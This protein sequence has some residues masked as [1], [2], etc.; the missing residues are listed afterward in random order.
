MTDGMK[1]RLHSAFSLPSCIAN[2]NR[3]RAAFIGVLVIGVGAYILVKKPL[4]VNLSASLPLGLYA[5]ADGE[6][7]TGKLVEFRRP[8][9][10]SNENR[11]CDP[12]ILKPILAGPGD[13]INTTGDWLIVNGRQIGPIHTTDSSG[14]PL[15]VWRANRTLKRDE[16]FVFS[17]RVWNSFDSRYFG[18]MD[19]G[20]AWRA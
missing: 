13:H 2:T 7:D 5:R 10:A 3:V 18:P 9:S 8:V 6:P 17:A 4:V 16:F 15:P 12:F 19:V 14:N 20:R 11:S 1:K